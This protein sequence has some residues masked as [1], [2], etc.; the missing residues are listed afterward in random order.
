MLAAPDSTGRPVLIAGNGPS[1][2]FPDYECIPAD[3][4]VVRT[5]WFFAEDV[6][7]FGSR[8]DVAVIPAGDAGHADDLAASPYQV[9]ATLEVNHVAALP[10]G[11]EAVDTAAATAA[12]PSYALQ[13]AERFLAAGARTVYLSGVDGYLSPAEGSSYAGSAVFQRLGSRFDGLVPPGFGPSTPA[14][15]ADD[16]AFLRKLLRD[17]PDAT[18]FAV[19]RQEGLE[20]LPLAPKLAGGS[21]SASPLA[22]QGVLRDSDA[23]QPWAEIDGRRCAYVTL[24]S[25][26]YHHGARALARSLGKVSAVPLIVMCGSDADLPAL[27]RSGLTCVAVPD[28]TNPHSHYSPDQ[29][30]FA[31]TFTKLNAFRLT[32]LDR[33]VFIDSDAIVLDSIDDLFQGDAFQAVPD[34]G[35]Q[36]DL[37][38]F[39]SGVFSTNPSRARFDAMIDRM[40]HTESDD[41]GDQGFLNAFLADDWTALPRSYNTTKRVA[42]HH[43]EQFDLHQVKVLHY[44]GIK[45]WTLKE[46]VGYQELNLLWIDQLDPVEA[47]ELLQAWVAKLAAPVDERDL[48][49]LQRARNAIKRGET[50]LAADLLRE[51]LRADPRSVNA[52]KLMTSLALERRDAPRALLYG[53]RAVLTIGRNTAAKFVRGKRE[54]E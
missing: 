20:D 24:V 25:G 44:V 51:E 40:E 49:L 38:W 2:Y 34:N 27:R 15:L 52:M 17:Y 1:A 21:C 5:P 50:D 10:A 12:V 42:S 48:P 35:L 16:R 30:R 11:P 36:L 26:D 14:Q 29:Q 7:H 32:F 41:G 6:F 45:P 18:I 47:K 37:P 46:S 53:G 43:P 13:A 19:G 31:A 33:I 22:D 54:A 8:V 9:D 3:V 28:I 23:A 39:N 4:I